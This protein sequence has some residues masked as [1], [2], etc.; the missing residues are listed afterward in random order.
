[1]LVFKGAESNDPRT[2]LVVEL[3]RAGDTA[4]ASAS[5]RRT[6]QKAPLDW[7]VQANVSLSAP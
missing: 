4:Q 2:E 7:Q 6:D 1:M 5:W 3:A